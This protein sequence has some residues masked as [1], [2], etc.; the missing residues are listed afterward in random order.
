[1]KKEYQKPQSEVI[2]VLHSKNLL[3]DFTSTE[4]VPGGGEGEP[5]S[6]RYNDYWD[7]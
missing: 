7:D 1:M 3:D 5:D 2:E 6:R 4:E